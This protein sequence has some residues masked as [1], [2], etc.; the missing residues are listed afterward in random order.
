MLLRMAA[1][2]ELVKNL[3]KSLNHLIQFCATRQNPLHGLFMSL[4][5]GQTGL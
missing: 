1:L 2:E 3:M 5:G 4:G